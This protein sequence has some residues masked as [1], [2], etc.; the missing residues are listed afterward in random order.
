MVRIQ[1]S[2]QPDKNQQY[3]E[4]AVSSQH[5]NNLYRTFWF[6]GIVQ[7]AVVH[8]VGGLGHHEAARGDVPVIDTGQEARRAGQ[9]DR[10]GHH[11]A[12]HWVSQRQLVVLVAPHLRSTA[13]VM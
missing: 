5:H 6:N 3:N 11:V 12:R 13:P 10:G 2:T 1:D 8:V 4:S 9:G 7:R